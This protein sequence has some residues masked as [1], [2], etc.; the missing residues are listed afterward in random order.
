MAVSSTANSTAAT[1][2]YIVD[3]NGDLPVILCEIADSNSISLGSL[4]KS[5]FYA[6]GQILCQRIHEIVEPNTLVFTPYYYVHDRLGS[7]RMVIDSA[8]AAVCSYTYKPYGQF[9]T[10]ECVETSGV[11][12][13]WKFTGQYYDAEIEQYYLRARQYDPQMM[14]FTSRDSVNGQ[15]ISPLTLHKYL[16]C[17]N[18]PIDSMDRIGLWLESIHRSF[19]NLCGGYA[20]LFDYAA[21]DIDKPAW[22]P[23]FNDLHFKTKKEASRDV[24]DAIGDGNF[25]EFGY[26]MH[27]WQDTYTHRDKGYKHWHGFDPKI[28]NP[29]DPALY[30]A[31]NLTTKFF[32]GLFL[33]S[34]I[35]F[36]MSS[37]GNVRLPESNPWF[38]TFD[39]SERGKGRA[40]LF[41]ESIYK[42][43]MGE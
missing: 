18:E 36:W 21:L 34:N 2:K 38:S 29:D 8:G 20:T 9:Y 19:G 13:P 6:D 24:L 14:R 42:E 41:L 37:S 40:S 3:I 26:S 4:K 23:L 27:E 11:D 12:N 31:C 5:Y 30:E 32:E 39:P 35:D 25:K 33:K 7:V 28:D 15:Y 43:M 10:G 17:Q 1:R 16:Y 22:N